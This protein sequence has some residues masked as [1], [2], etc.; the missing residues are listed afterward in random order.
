MFLKLMGLTLGTVKPVAYAS[1]V[2]DV[3]Q[4]QAGEPMVELMLNW[5]DNMQILTI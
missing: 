2:L 1:V 3:L 4:I 5:E